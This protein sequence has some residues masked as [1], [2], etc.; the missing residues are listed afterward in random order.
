MKNIL[1]GSFILMLMFGAALSYGQS[2]EETKKQRT[3]KMQE[4]FEELKTELELTDDQAEQL[5][6]LYKERKE[7][8]QSQRP[9]KEDINA[10][11]PDQKKELKMYQMKLKKQLTDEMNIQVAEILNEEQL[12]KY[13]TISK[14]KKLEA[15]KRHQYQEMEGQHDNKKME[16]GDVHQHED[17]VDHKH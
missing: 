4:E 13:K 16:E 14:E 9:S 2:M 7:K 8:L 5:K 1:K 10:M 6:T 3:L 12:V 17:G 15:K 11:N